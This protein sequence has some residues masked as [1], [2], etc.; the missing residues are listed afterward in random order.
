MC[1]TAQS[2]KVLFKANCS[3]AGDQE[4]H[5]LAAAADLAVVKVD[6]NDGIG[7]EFSG[8]SGEL[9]QAG[10][11]RF[12]QRLLMGAATPADDVPKPAQEVSKDVDAEHTFSADDAQGRLNLMAWD[13]VGG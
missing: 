6:S 10:F 2:A 3:A 4:H 13:G 9:L 7:A 8:V 11:P 5:A 12:P 1:L